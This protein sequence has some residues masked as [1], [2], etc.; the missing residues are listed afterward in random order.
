MMDKSI[1]IAPFTGDDFSSFLIADQ[2]RNDYNVVSIYTPGGFAVKECDIGH[3][4]NREAYGYTATSDFDAAMKDAD[5]V[6]I[7]QADPESDLFRHAQDLIK[8]AIAAG[9][10]VISLLDLDDDTDN[11]YRL[12]CRQKGLSYFSYRCESLPPVAPEDTYEPLHKLQT[13]VIVIGEFAPHMDADEVVSLLAKEFIER[14]K[15]VSIVSDRNEIGLL[16]STSVDFSKLQNRMED[17]VYAINRYMEKLERT[18]HPGII[19]CKLPQPIVEFNE[20]IRYDF[21]LSAFLISRAISPTFFVLCSAYGSFTEE[22]WESLATN[23]M[24][25][26]SFCIDVINISNKM[27]DT[28]ELNTGGEIS[29]LRRPVADVADL[30]GRAT[31]DIPLTSLLLP[32]YRKAFCDLVLS[33][34]YGSTASVLL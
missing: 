29:Y 33:E 20:D 30:L 12:L 24:E 18:E 23:C 4:Y 9:K 25:K 31:T 16:G 21:G 34:T 32:E 14:D 11:S 13:P 1:C 22:T 7:L 2:I 17:Q 8:K 5:T 3:A 15:K 27:V 10:H 6:L 28:T 26:L 19:I